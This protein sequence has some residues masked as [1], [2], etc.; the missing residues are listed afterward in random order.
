[1]LCMCSGTSAFSARSLLGKIPIT[2]GTSLQGEDFEQKPQIH[3]LKKY[4]YH[5]ATQ[6]QKIHFT[7]IRT[8]LLFVGFSNESARMQANYHDCNCSRYKRDFLM[9][10]TEE[11]CPGLGYMP[12]GSW[13]KQTDSSQQ[14]LPV[15]KCSWAPYLL[16]ASVACQTPLRK[17]GWD[18]D[19]GIFVL[20]IIWVAQPVL[21]SRSVPVRHKLAVLSPLLP[22]AL[23]MKCRNKTL[24]VIV[25]P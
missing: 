16:I 22:T 3:S 9:V 18:R 21:A 15:R 17:W 19:L 14:S 11:N 5:W 13:S 6:N 20:N 2:V 7:L 10:A 8:L 12:W 25:L 1:M 4:T 24:R 23:L